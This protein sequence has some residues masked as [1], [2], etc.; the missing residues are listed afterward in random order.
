[1]L[2]SVCPNMKTKLL[3]NYTEVLFFMLVFLIAFK[4][5]INNCFLL[6]PPFQVPPELP[7]KQLEKWMHLILQAP[8]LFISLIKDLDIC[9]I[10]SQTSV[11]VPQQALNFEAVFMHCKF[12]FPLPHLRSRILLYCIPTLVLLSCCYFPCNM[13]KEKCAGQRLKKPSS[14][15]SFFLLLVYLLLWNSIKVCSM[16][17]MKIQIFGKDSNQFLSYW[18]NASDNQNWIL[19][20]SIE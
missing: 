12:L 16:L 2:F 9:Q 17:G 6:H 11:L 19:V 20:M 1:M 3:R 13:I 5:T 4:N 18:S 14:F 8:L 7:L 15:D 10:D